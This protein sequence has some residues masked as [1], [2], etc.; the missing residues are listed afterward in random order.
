MKQTISAIRAKLSRDEAITNDEVLELCEQ[1]DA[2]IDVS[3]RMERVI[4]EQI[5]MLEA[6]ALI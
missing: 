3:L 1:A 6:A 4:H 2:M 5:K